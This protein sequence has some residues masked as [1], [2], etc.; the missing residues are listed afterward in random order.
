MLQ[1]NVVVNNKTYVVYH[2]FSPQTLLFSRK[3]NTS[4]CY[5]ISSHNLGTV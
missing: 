3:L 4:Y 1:P 2:T 5:V